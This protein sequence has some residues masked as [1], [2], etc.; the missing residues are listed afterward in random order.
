MFVLT[1]LFKLTT[2]V[3]VVGTFVVG[4]SDLLS[5]GGF[6][7]GLWGKPLRKLFR[8]MFYDLKGCKLLV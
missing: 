2:Y 4:L 3:R 8:N 7:G 1:G 5:R 6:G